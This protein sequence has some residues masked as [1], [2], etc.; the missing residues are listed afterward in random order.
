MLRLP[1]VNTLKKYAQFTTAGSGFNP[2]IIKRLIEEAKVESSKPF[3]RNVVLSYDE[4]QIK[5]QL[6]RITNTTNT[7]ILKIDWANDGFTEMCDINEEFRI[8]QGH[9]EE[10]CKV[11]SCLGEI[12]RDFATFVLFTWSEVYF[13]KCG[14]YFWLL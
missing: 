2:D 4:M 9:V 7:I 14:V 3:Q 12:K 11:N 8:F 5:S 1:H 6:V 13:Y 10:S